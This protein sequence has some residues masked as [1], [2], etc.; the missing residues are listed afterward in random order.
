MRPDPDR[1]GPGVDARYGRLYRGRMAEWLTIEV[2]DGAFPASQWRRAHERDLVESALTHGARS[3]QWHHTGWGVVLELLFDD[4]DRLAGF[5]ALPGVRAALDAAPD[6][7]SGVLV[8]RGPGGGAGASVPR[9]PRRG[10]RAGA[11][12]L[13]EPPAADVV[14]VLCLAR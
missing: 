8:Y 14:E 7:V 6:P 12:A 13:P 3:W 5:R 10:P 9:R 2:F 1:A 11:A 4:D